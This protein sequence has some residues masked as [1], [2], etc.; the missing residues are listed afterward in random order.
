MKDWRGELAVCAGLLAAVAVT[1]ATTE[2]VS[3][4]IF[5]MASA[6]A[7]VGLAGAKV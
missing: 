5:V 2:L 6:F 1:M 4:L 3:A 7:F